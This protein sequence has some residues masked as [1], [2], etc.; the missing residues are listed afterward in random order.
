M[1]KL[2]RIYCEGGLV[3]SVLNLPEG[4]DY[5]IIDYDG[6]DDEPRCGNCEKASTCELLEDAEGCVFELNHKAQEILD[7]QEKE[8]KER[9][10]KLRAEVEEIMDS[11]DEHTISETLF[12]LK[13]QVGKRKS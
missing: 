3:T 8:E 5:K 1:K 4:W 11:G 7:R 9:E 13:K 6:D 10:E 2:A 12:E